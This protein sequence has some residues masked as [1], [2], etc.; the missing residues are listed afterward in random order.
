[1][2]N[3]FILFY[4]KISGCLWI[5]QALIEETHELA[6]N[7][8]CCFLEAGQIQKAKDLLQKSE[9]VG[10]ATMQEK[11]LNEDEITDELQCV[12]VQRAYIA[13]VS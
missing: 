5:S 4:F 8:A 12:Q 6:F 1:M 11:G 9:T 2:K 10:R 13:Q 7:A 3:H